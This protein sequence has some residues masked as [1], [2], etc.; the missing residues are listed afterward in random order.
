MPVRHQQ[1]MKKNH[2]EKITVIALGGSIVFPHKFTDGGLNVPFLMEFRKFILEQTAKGRRFVLV[3]GGGKAAR[4]YQHVAKKIADP[5]Q[6]A[7]DW[8]GIR[9]TRL[10][11][12]LILDILKEVAHPFIIHYEPSVD[13]ARILSNCEHRVVIAAG[14]GPGWSTDYVAVKCAEIFGQKETI[15]DGDTAFVYNKDPNKFKD[16]MPVA[17]ITWKEY[18]KLIPDIWTPGMSAPVDPVAA[19]FAKENKIIIK[20]VQGTNLKNFLRVIEGKTFEGTTIHN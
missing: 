19:R 4:L 8:L 17:D 16:A 3:V 12:Q 20:T 13:E 10:N 2:K 7:L 15:I 5:G 6:E 18:N 9:A 1:F 11:A 14:W